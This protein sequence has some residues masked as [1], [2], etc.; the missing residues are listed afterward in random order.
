M[1]QPLNPG[2]QPRHP[3]VLYPDE[4]LGGGSPGQAADSGRAGQVERAR[5]VGRVVGLVGRDLLQG[6]APSPLVA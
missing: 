2:Q 3:G 6:D 5:A 4:L 1:V